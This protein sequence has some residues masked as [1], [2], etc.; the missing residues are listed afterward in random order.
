MRT[1]IVLFQIRRPPILAA[2]ASLAIVVMIFANA[3]FLQSGQHPAPLFNAREAPPADGEDAKGLVEAVQAALAKAG[4][5]S[6]PVDGIAGPQTQAA[7]RAFQSA[8][9]LAEAGQVTPMLLSALRADA[10]AVFRRDAKA[11]AADGVQH[12]RLAD[13][14]VAEVQR[15]LARSAYGPLTSDGLFGPG[16]RAAIERFQRDHG[17]PVTGE[18]S[19]PL[20]VELRSAG[21]WDSE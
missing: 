1:R 13:P 8:R 10:A 5:Y 4:Y 7:V 9:G 14:L 3:T 16:T 17:L 18:I 15:A 19:E 12:T 20:V 11:A 21:A 2:A 6:G